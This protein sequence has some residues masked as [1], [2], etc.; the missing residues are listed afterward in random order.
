M[1]PERPQNTDSKRGRLAALLTSPAMFLR[2]IDPVRGLAVFS[3]MS[4]ESYRASSFLDNRIIRAAEKDVIAK[5][6]DLLDWVA[7]L[8]PERRTIDYI[9]HIGHCGSTLLSRILGQ[10]D[11]FL[12]IREPPLLMGLSRS[13][14]ALDHPGFP[15]SEDRW[16]AIKDLGLLTLSKTWREDQSPLVKPT[17]HAGNLIPT[18]MAHTGRERAVLLYVDLETYLA[19]MLRAHIRQESRLYAREFRVRQFTELLPDQPGSSDD[20][21]DAELTAMNWL[22]QT[23]DLALAEDAPGNQGRV[24]RL[25]FE[26]FLDDPPGT[27]GRLCDF[28]GRPASAAECRSLA[29]E[30]QLGRSAKLP[31]I[32]HGHEKR[33]L[34][35]KLSREKHGAEIE[36][37]LAWAETICDTDPFRDLHLRFA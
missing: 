28:L 32:E 21:S 10:R 29:S 31:E 11:C 20:Y 4:E 14:R 7:E 13:L 19:T 2:D 8:K 1:T 17:S 26:T 15:I 25:R 30:E 12:S 9:L 35:L 22:L 27:I 18:L 6:D 24:M 23:R 36:E 16:E 5:L 34:Q 3:P 33:Q 37:A